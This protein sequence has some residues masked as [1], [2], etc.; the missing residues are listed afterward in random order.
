[1]CKLR[2]KQNQKEYWDVINFIILIKFVKLPDRVLA[3][4]HLHVLH[5]AALGG[6]VA[7]AEYLAMRGAESSSTTNDG[8][9]PL[10]AT[11]HVAIAVW[12][13]FGAL[14]APK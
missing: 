2:I 4:D 14:I 12:V 7:F 3:L 1:M 6:H 5:V 10:H 11:A 13:R 8:R 9:Q